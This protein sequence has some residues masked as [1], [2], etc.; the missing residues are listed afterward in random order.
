MKALATS[1]VFRSL[2][3][4]PQRGVWQ[5]STRTLWVA[6]L[7]LGKAATFR[8]LG[9]PAPSGTTDENLRRLGALADDWRARRLIVLGDFLHA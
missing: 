4:L 6:D 7:H 9:Q 2:T 3:M 1:L 8:A 5:A